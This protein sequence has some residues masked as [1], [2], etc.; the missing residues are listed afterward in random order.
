VASVVA[1][2]TVV[3]T[4]INNVVSTNYAGRLTI[5]AGVVNAGALGKRSR[6]CGSGAVLV[7]RRCVSTSFGS[8]SATETAAGT[9]LLQVKPSKIA[10]RALAAGKTLHVTETVTLVPST[11]GIGAATTTVHVTIKGAKHKKKH[12]RRK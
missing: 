4:V 9:F 12:R 8:T 11:A 6:K 5:V 2:A 3:K 7:H 10:R 1:K